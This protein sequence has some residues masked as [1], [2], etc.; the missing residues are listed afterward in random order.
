LNNM[1]KVEVRSPLGL[2]LGH[3]EGLKFSISRINRVVKRI[4]IGLYW[5]HHETRLKSG[6][7]FLIWKDPD[8]NGIVDIINNYTITPFIDQDTFQY[9]MVLRLKIQM[10]LYGFC[11]FIR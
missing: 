8:V 3:A 2:Y 4:V 1:V 10:Y 6:L 11:G 5:H 9:R 7:D